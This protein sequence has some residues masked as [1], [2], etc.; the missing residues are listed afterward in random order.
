LSLQQNDYTNVLNLV[1]GLKKPKEQMNAKIILLEDNNDG[2]ESDDDD[3]NHE[4]T[5]QGGVRI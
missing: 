4:E 3:H 1:E 5:S 2:E